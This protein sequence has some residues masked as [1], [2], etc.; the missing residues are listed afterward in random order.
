M[1]DPAFADELGSIGGEKGITAMR[2]AGTT[3]ITAEL[4]REGRY[5]LLCHGQ[6]LLF[7]LPFFSPLDAM[8]PLWQLRDTK[9]ILLCPSL[10]RPVSEHF[11]FIS[12]LMTGGGKPNSRY[13][14][15]FR[16]VC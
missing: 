15:D 13:L 12:T 3:Q 5:A 8:C 1:P 11:K 7:R 6:Q 14:S 9:V 2:A 4:K 16:T 10:K